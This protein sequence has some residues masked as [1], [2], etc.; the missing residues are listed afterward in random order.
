MPNLKLFKLTQT[1]NRGYDTYDSFVVCASDKK[2]ARHYNP[3]TGKFDL[4]EVFTGDDYGY[5]GWCGAIYVEVQEIGLANDGI[6]EGFII[7]SFH[8]G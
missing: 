2:T 3:E 8:A 5:S 6:K 1:K 4:P 7:G